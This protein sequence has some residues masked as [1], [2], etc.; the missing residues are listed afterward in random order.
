MFSYTGYK[1]TGYTLAEVLIT[2]GIIGTVAAMTIP[3]L[4]MSYQKRVWESK[5][6]KIYSIA[7]NACERMLIEENVSAVNE[8]DLYAGVTNEKLRKYFKLMLDGE[9]VSGKGFS[10]TLPDGGVLYLT[11]A[12]DGFKFITDVNGVATR[13]NMAGKDIFEF[14]LDKNCAYNNSAENTSTE[15]KAFKVVVEN[16]WKIPDNY[17][18]SNS[19]SSNPSSTSSNNDSGDS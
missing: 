9:E 15:A 2:I 5:L 8:T 3:S 6:K 13:P 12:E 14:R 10:I 1:K 17:P 19:G 4:M 18:S 11:A 7:T 16:D